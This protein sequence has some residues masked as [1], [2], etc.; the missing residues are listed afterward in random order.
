MAFLKEAAFDHDIGW[1]LDDILLH[2]RT[3]MPP[4]GKS[5]IRDRAKTEALHI[6]ALALSLMGEG[7]YTREE[8]LRIA[9]DKF[10][11]LYSFG[12]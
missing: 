9:M 4:K 11:N 6:M 12:T 3:G 7:V 8:A 10:S 1:A 5:A 2:E